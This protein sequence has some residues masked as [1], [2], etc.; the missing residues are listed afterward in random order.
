[1]RFTVRGVVSKAR[2]I[3]P[4]PIDR[5]STSVGL[6]AG[7]SSRAHQAKDAASAWDS[8]SSS[9]KS[10]D[11]G[12]IAVFLQVPWNDVV[13][14]H[15]RVTALAAAEIGFVA[16]VAGDVGGDVGAALHV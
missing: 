10:M 11:M 3:V 5:A 14:L 12:D 13:V 4:E 6:P 1:M 9:V 8:S 16:E 2:R 15:N 7:P